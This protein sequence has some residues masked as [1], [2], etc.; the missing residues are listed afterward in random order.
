MT[1]SWFQTKAIAIIVS[2]TEP[3][4]TTAF[5]VVHTALQVVF[6][7]TLAC[8]PSKKIRHLGISRKQ[9]IPL[10][11]VLFFGFLTIIATILGGFYRLAALTGF[12]SSSNWARAE[13]AASIEISVGV[14]CSSFFAWKQLWNRWFKRCD[15]TQNTFST[16]EPGRKKDEQSSVEVGKVESTEDAPNAEQSYKDTW[17]IYV[18][19]DTV[20]VS[21]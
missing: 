14:A 8:L 3:V 4:D 7:A 21:L 16:G 17:D 12:E 6:N 19:K 13:L 20:L 11:L 15:T 5:V 9:K 18:M 2:N 1:R 10:I